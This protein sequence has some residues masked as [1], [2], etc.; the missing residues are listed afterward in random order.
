MTTFIDLAEVREYG[1]IEAEGTVISPARLQTLGSTPGM[2]TAKL[3]RWT[4]TGD[5]MAGQW[6]EW[7]HLELATTTNNDDGS[8]TVVGRSEKLGNEVGLVGQDAEVRW[9]VKPRG[10]AG[11]R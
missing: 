7:D 10:C 2:S 4:P 6:E 5:G 9:E 1:G 3:Y 11:C 8:V